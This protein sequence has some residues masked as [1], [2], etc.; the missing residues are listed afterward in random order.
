MIA[1][2]AKKSGKPP[3]LVSL[4]ERAR[5]FIIKWKGEDVMRI[6][7]YRVEPADD[8]ST[9]ERFLRRRGVSRRVRVDLK[10]DPEGLTVAGVPIRT[11][12]RLHTGD[13]LRLCLR[14]TERSDIVA[15]AGLP[16]TVVY[17]DEDL[18]VLDKPADMAV[19]PSPGNRENTV[20]NALAGLC[21]ARGEP[22]VFRAIGRL[23][24]NT[25]GLLVAAKNALAAGI[26]TQAAA[27]KRLFREYLAVCTGELPACGVIDAPI[28]RKDGTALGRE[29]RPD[30]ERAVTH[31]ERLCVRDGF[32]LARIW[33]E[34]GRTHQ[35]RVHMQHIGHPLPGDFLYHPDFSRIGRH[36]LHAARL[37]VPQPVTGEI[38]RFSSPLPADMR[39]FFPDTENGCPSQGS[40][41][42]VILPG[43]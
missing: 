10:N 42:A 27:E 11:I 2:H 12:D 16:L 6:V 26:L 30:G 25:S 41:S 21:A 39:L 3:N 40:R 35:I 5:L 34:T 7:E 18:F 15:Q 43:Q 37:T 33:L 4:T 22:F 14:E 36:A 13:L 23:D 32:S 29:V 38:L 20:A 17:E 8:G 24:K 9:V 31:F 1:L 28:G 19:H